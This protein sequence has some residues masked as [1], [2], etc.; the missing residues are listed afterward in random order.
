ML[1]AN[2]QMVPLTTEVGKVPCEQQLMWASEIAFEKYAFLT[3][4]TDLSKGNW[5]N[6]PEPYNIFSLGH[7]EFMH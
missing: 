2:I 5:V 1:V 4:C 7:R 6:I 3:V